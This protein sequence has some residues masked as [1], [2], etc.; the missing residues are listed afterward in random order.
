MTLPVPRPRRTYASPAQRRAVLNRDGWVC[1]TCGVHLQDRDPH[2]PDYAHAGHRIDHADGGP[3]TDHNLMAQCAPCNLA[4]GGDTDHHAG[5]R[6]V[7][8]F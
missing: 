7:T 2:A 3:T 4:A 8:V 6:G 1:Q 5:V